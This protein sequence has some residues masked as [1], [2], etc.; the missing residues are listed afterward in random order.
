M[1]TNDDDLNLRR[2]T[3]AVSVFSEW[4]P[5]L[6][7]SGVTTTVLGDIKDPKFGRTYASFYA[8]CRL[9]T[10]NVTFGENPILDSIVLTLKY[11]NKYGAFDQPVNVSVFE[12]NQSIFDSVP[13]KTNDAFGVYLPAIGQ[14]SN[15]IPNLTD[16]VYEIGGALPAHL[17]VTLSS[18]LGNKI[19]LANPADLQD[20]NTFLNLFK[21]FYITA[22][23]PGGGNGLIYFDPRST[24]SKISLYYQNSSA[25]SLVYDIPLSGARFNHFDNIYTGTAVNSSVTSP[26]P[27]GEELMY[28]QS[29][30]GVRGRI[31]I[32]NLDSL[33]DNIAINKAE[34]VLSRSPSDTAYPGP[35]LLDLF[36]I[37]DAG[38]PQKLEDDALNSFGGTSVSEIVDGVSIIRYRF[39][40]RKYFQKLIKGVYHNNGFFLQTL[41]AETTSERLVISNSS[42]DKKYSVTLIVTYTKL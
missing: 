8:Q 16:S 42:T 3:L 21:G 31:N 25:D 41:S 2:D 20:N 32:S 15:F 28:I 9:L 26:N 7:S 18:A 27:A 5:P 24:F 6:V 39:N 38:Q 17:R 12:M 22:T 10:N 33:P 19:L 29:G 14:V 4:V 11:N 23:A 40:I 35:L 1:L 30:A 13:Y 37:D 36:R 34:L